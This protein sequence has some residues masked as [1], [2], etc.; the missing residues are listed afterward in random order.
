[1]CAGNTPSKGVLSATLSIRLSRGATRREGNKKTKSSVLVLLVVPVAIIQYS[2]YLI[3]VIALAYA[4]AMF[5]LLVAVV[6]SLVTRLVLLRRSRSRAL[7]HTT[8]TQRAWRQF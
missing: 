4:I 8:T 1:M 6:S 7:I 3:A 2:I 5:L